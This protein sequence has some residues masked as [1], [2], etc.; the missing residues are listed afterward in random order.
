MIWSTL[1]RVR[2]VKWPWSLGALAVVIRKNEGGKK[3]PWRLPQGMDFS[4][5]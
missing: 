2:R 1:V 4:L 3:M 5:T